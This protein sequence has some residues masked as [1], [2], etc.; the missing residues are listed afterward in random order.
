[1]AIPMFVLGFTEDSL[2]IL[3]EGERLSKELGD[4]KSFAHFLSLIGQYYSFK[5]EDLPVGV[6]YCEAA[7]REAER[8]DDN[9]YAIINSLKKM[10]LKIGQI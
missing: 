2:E 5:G 4:E 7:F 8:I 3:Q 1:M 10:G 6:Q 9:S